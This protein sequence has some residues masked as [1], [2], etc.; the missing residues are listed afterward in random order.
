MYFIQATHVSRQLKP[1]SFS[2]AG[3]ATLFPPFFS[4]ALTHAQ[5]TAQRVRYDSL[6]LLLYSYKMRVCGQINLLMDG[7]LCKNARF[8]REDHQILIFITFYYYSRFARKDKIINYYFKL[9]FY[10]EFCCFLNYFNCVV[11]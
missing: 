10:L 5:G 9:L 1:N 2:Q 8:T 4:R 6:N 7:G 11:F 3:R